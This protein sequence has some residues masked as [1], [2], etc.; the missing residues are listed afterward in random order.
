MLKH[1]PNSSINSNPHTA[2][3]L[4]AIMRQKIAISALTP[5][6][7]I[8]QISRQYDTSRKFVY[9]Q[10][11]KASD[12][13][14]EVFSGEID[15]SKVL[16]YIP[17]TKGWLQQSVMS[18]ILSCHSSYGGV[19][20]FF[21]DIFDS[22]ICKGT[23]FNIME[24]ALDK[25][26]H[27]NNSQ[28]LSLIKVGAHDEIFQK[29]TPVLVGCDVHSTYVYLL[30][31]VEQR[32]QITWGV[33]LLDLSEQGMKLEYSIA[34]AG[35]G[36]R[37]GQE[38]AWPNIPCR[39]DVFHPLYD[40]GKLTTFLENR[41]NSA[42]TIVKQ[43]EQKKKKAKRNLKP[44]FLRRLISARKEAK[45][46]VQLAK[47]ITL[48]SQWLKNDILSVTGPDFS[49]RQELLK[50]VVAELE[51][52]EIYCSHRIKPVRRLLGLQGENLLAFVK[53]IDLE[54]EQLSVN[55]GVD[56]Y[57]VRSLFELQ[58]VSTTTG[59]YWEKTKILHHKIGKCFYRLQKNLE[60]LIKST[61]RA[62][63]IVENLNSRLRNY[64]FLRKT[65]GPNYLELL[66]FYINHRRYMRSSRPERKGKS[67]KELLTSQAHKHW[68]E[69]LGY[70]LFK[71]SE[72]PV[73]AKFIFKRAA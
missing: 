43:L 42:L 3:Q 36:L 41:A 52:R 47:D 51:A 1:H 28:D 15:D 9:A 17:V 56:I 25:A 35:K 29:Q 6:E 34:D 67:P 44:K 38:L 32:D 27:M 54:L 22:N 12:A 65:L 30:K 59:N 14:N 66:Q 10:K 24:G 16:F 46:A 69:C 57:L 18:L 20:E 48:L 37:R 2:K 4:D 70:K 68:L 50:F 62:S 26:K 53:D 72:A 64:F 33:H 21:R 60:K 5:N 45:I 19:I 63:S 13:L 49:S 55:Y 31:Q 73:S 40:I 71:K 7:N 61:V 39:G 23:I 58:G 11:E 8:S